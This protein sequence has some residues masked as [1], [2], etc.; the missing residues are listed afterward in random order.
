MEISDEAYLKAATD[1]FITAYVP[2]LRGSGLSGDA[3]AAECVKGIAALHYELKQ[4]Y[5]TV[6]KAVREAAE[7]APKPI[8][9]LTFRMPKL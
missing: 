5:G 2:D 4:Q 3:L 9:P 7:G 6:L 8:G 1:I